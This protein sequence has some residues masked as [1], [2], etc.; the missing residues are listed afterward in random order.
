MSA[1]RKTITRRT[2]QA[3]APKPGA[4]G[5]RSTGRLQRAID[6]AAHREISMALK[7]AAG[8]MA[9]A[10]RHLGISYKGLW[11]RLRSLGID[12]ARFRE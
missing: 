10:A 12:P 2:H 1:P 6:E 7:E 9:E 11:K 4:A 5:P 3:K 8:N